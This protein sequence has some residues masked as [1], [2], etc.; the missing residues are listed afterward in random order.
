MNTTWNVTSTKTVRE[1]QSD[2][3]LTRGKAITDTKGRK[4]GALMREYKNKVAC[5]SLLVSTEQFVNAGQWTVTA[6]SSSLPA[7][8]FVNN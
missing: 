8:H 2:N 1:K 3:F 7:N 5:P 4:N 6:G